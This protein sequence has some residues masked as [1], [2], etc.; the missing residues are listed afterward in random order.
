[1]DWCHPMDNTSIILIIVAIIITISAGL[2]F[3]QFLLKNFMDYRPDNQFDQ[4]QLKQGIKIEK[5]HTKLTFVAKN[6]AKDHLEEFPNYYN[7]KT[8]L[9]AMEK[10]LK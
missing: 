6:I 1:M 9:P 8:G 2:L 4:K 10:R 5:E 7:E 3:I